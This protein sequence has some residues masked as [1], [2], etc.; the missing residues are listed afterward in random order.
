MR[1]AVRRLALL[2][3]LVCVVPHPVRGA[4]ADEGAARDEP[5]REDAADVDKRRGGAGL[6]PLAEYLRFARGDSST[7]A[8]K[9]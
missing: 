1:S 4:V 2:L 5:L 3:A 8:R 7:P 9:K 6:E